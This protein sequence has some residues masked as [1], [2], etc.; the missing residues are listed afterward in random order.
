M[1]LLVL[2]VKEPHLERPYKTWLITPVV[3][4]A[5]RSSALPLVDITGG[6][7]PSAYADL[8]C[9]WRS[10]GGFWYVSWGR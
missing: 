10:G 5:V 8:C 7:L 1:G 2:R 9:A 6:P 4:C 3:F